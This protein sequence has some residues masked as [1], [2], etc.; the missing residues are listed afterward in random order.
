MAPLGKGNHGNAEWV[1]IDG[2]P[3]ERAESRDKLAPLGFWQDFETK[4]LWVRPA[5]GQDISKSNVEYAW[6]EGLFVAEGDVNDVHIKGFT[7]THNA[8]CAATRPLPE[9]AARIC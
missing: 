8:N 5:E 2:S 9:R 6:R 7:L 4:R 3:L 1:Y